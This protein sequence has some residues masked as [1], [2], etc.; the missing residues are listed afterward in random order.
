MSSQELKEEFDCLLR[1]AIMGYVDEDSRIA[2]WCSGGIDSSTLLYYL[3][4]Y[5]VTAIHLFF[6]PDATTYNLHG[7]LVDFLTVKSRTYGMHLSD[8]WTLLHTALLAHPGKMSAFPT[9]L[10]YMCQVSEDYDIILHGTGM[11][12]LVGGYRQHAQ[13]SDEEFPMVEQ[14]YYD[15]VHT[16][17]HNTEA[18]ALARGLAIESPFIDAGLQTFS[19]AL[20]RR[21]KTHGHH[22]KILLRALMVGRI[23]EAN[24][25]SGLV[26]G[27]KGGFHPPIREWW[28]Q[29]LEE[30]TMARLGVIDRFRTRRNLWKRIIRANEKE[31]EMLAYEKWKWKHS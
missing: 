8:H 31:K 23:P 17:K 20:P 29:G 22:T 1:K 4:D 3:K 2:V 6:P 10:A 28:A 5:D 7:P 26:A 21:Y 25:L 24:R 15:T 27:S 12:E 11:D 14:H 30:W 19:Q 18:Q 13:A 9:M 16:F